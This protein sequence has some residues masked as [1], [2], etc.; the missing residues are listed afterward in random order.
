MNIESKYR[1]V[2]LG[3]PFPNI[4]TFWGILK[5]IK[6]ASTFAKIEAL[7][8]YNVHERFILSVLADIMTSNFYW[9][10]TKESI[11]DEYS[12]PNYV[13]DTQFLDYHPTEKAIYKAASCTYQS[14]ALLSI[15]G[16][17]KSILP[18][19]Q[20][21]SLSNLP[22][23][24]VEEKK[25]LIRSLNYSLAMTKDMYQTLSKKLKTTYSHSK[26]EILNIKTTVRHLAKEIVDTE[27]QI[28]ATQKEISF[29][30]EA[31]SNSL[32]QPKRD[33][34]YQQIIDKLKEIKLK[35][36]FVKPFHQITSKELQDFL[37]DLD[38][39]DSGTKTEL[40]AR[41]QDYTVEEDQKT[42]KWFLEEILVSDLVEVHGTK[43]AHLVLY[44]MNLWTTQIDA[45]VIIFS[46]TNSFL[47]EL[48]VLLGKYN[49]ESTFVKGN[50]HQRN[51]A[52]GD[53]KSLT[54]A[55]V[56]MLSLENAASGTNLVEATHVIL[57]DPMTGSKTE[58]QAIES[59][60]IGR[61]Y[62][63]G[64]KHQLSIVRFIIR[65]TLEYNL[66]LRNNTDDPEDDQ[67]VESKDNRK[68]LVRTK[69]YTTKMLNLSE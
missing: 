10:N 50:I 45:R 22:A 60:A 23:K 69:N 62:R 56:I 29:Y 36:T 42:M 38:L 32:D 57:I 18:D 1:W 51:K 4:K 40:M 65:D 34:T 58:A 11:K 47:K 48:K 33:K 68:A 26:E 67:D 52:I 46:R 41:L 54:K 5:F 2:V 19:H 63:Q 55:R 7:S 43:L 25:Q 49:I 61:A 16:N 53:F 8:C 64:Q 30:Q 35:R 39:D 14:S 59:Q 6:F 21:I 24:L 31:I 20:N 12:I 17:P 3:T 28:V 37:G 66:F 27:Q 44:L 13:G 15:I 9:R